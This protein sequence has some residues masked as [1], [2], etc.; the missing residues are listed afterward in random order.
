M[1]SEEA[2][3]DI[4]QGSIKSASYHMILQ[5]SFRVVT[6]LLNALVL[7]NVDKAVLGILNVRLMLLVMTILF[8]S[9]ESFRKAC[10]SKTRDHNWPQVINLLW[11]TVPNVIFWSFTFCYIWLHVLELPSEEHIADYQFTVYVVGICCVIESFMEP[12]YLFSQAFLYVK[13]RLLVDCIMLAARIGILVVI[14]LYYPA[15]TIKSFAY[16][17]ATA[18]TLL[19]VSYW[20][21]FWYQFHKKA[22]LMKNRELHKNDPL[23]VLP[24]SSLKDFLPRKLEGQ[25]FIGADMAFLTWGFFKQVY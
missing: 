6:F 10:L 22:I 2:N 12:V 9:R 23:L 16:G 17:Q 5:I 7:H 3:N 18:S 19:L 14:V 21:Y 25:A 24:F 20:A 4:L 13:F 15:H 8:V 11:L 1:D